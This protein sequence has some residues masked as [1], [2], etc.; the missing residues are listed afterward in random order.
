MNDAATKSAEIAAIKYAHA[1]A[2]EALDIAVAG[3]RWA[4]VAKYAAQLA[5][6]EEDLY[7]AEP[8]P[9]WWT[10]KAA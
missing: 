7:R 2:K 3:G 9:C 4:A 1:D 10:R 5:R 8:A 6:I